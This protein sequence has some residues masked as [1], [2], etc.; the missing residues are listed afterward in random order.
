MD[1]FWNNTFIKSSS[2]VL[3]RLVLT[4]I[5]PLKNLK[6]NKEMYGGHLDAV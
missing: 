1:I 4:E 6:I 2:L 5:Q 3:I